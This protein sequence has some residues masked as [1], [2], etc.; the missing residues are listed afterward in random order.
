MLG[1][2]WA[3]AEPDVLP[4]GEEAARATRRWRCTSRRQLPG[5]RGHLQV[6]ISPRQVARQAQG[7]RLGAVQPRH[8][9]R[10][11]RGRGGAHRQ[12]KF[13][14]KP[15]TGEQV[16]WGLEN[17]DLSA[18]RMKELGFEGLLLPL[19]VT[20]DN[21]DG[22]RPPASTNGTASLE[23]RLRLVPR[24]RKDCRRWSRTR[25][26]NTPRRRRSPPATARRRAELSTIARAVL[27][28]PASRGDGAASARRDEC[29]TTAASDP[30]APVR[31]GHSAE[32]GRQAHD[33]RHHCSRSTTSRSSTTTSSWCLRACRWRCRRAA[34]SRCSAPTAPARRRRSRRSRT[35]C[36][37]SAARS[38]KAASCA[39]A[40]GSTG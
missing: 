5:A 16:R 24:G 19:K 21:H 32:R 28:F 10:D 35:C 18:D 17:L 13:G 8:D 39:A 2:W 29:N 38:P 20:C 30:S 7:C 40:R 23:V 26:R 37:A 34:S 33:R 4:A 3:G 1:V 27:P 15:L 9:Q 6:R 31:R 25:R 14:N 36:A 12:A 11:V 22:A